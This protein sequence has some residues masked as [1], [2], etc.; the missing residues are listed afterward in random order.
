MVNTIG[1]NGYDNGDVPDSETLRDKLMAYV[2]EQLTLNQ[3]LRRLEVELGYSIGLTKLKQIQ[4]ELGIPTSRK[5]PSLPAATTLVCEKMVEDAHGGRGPNSI[6]TQLALEGNPLPRSIIRSVMHAH[7]PEGAALRYPGGRTKVKQRGFLRAFGPFHEW[8]ADG[9]EKLS[10]KA[11]RIG[12]VGMGIYGITDKWTRQII[13]TKCYPDVR[14]AAAVGHILADTISEV[15]AICIQLTVDHGSETADMGGLQI[16]LRYAIDPVQY[17]PFLTLKSTDNIS[18]E[19]KWKWWLEFGG[20]NLREEMLRGTEIGIFNGGNPLH[21][22]LFQWLW[23]QI[24]QLVLDDFKHAWNAKRI[25]KQKNVLLPTGGTPN[26]FMVRPQDYGGER[27]SI[28]VDIH[29][30]TEIR[31][32]FD[33]TREDAFRW[34]DDVFADAAFYAY[35]SIGSPELKVSTAWDTFLRML[36]VLSTTVTYD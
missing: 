27:V 30:V 15:G 14:H 10:S 25:R 11:L 5:P 18:I 22:D 4:R 19:S 2:G 12:P 31:S 28:P 24:V 8:H 29:N 16:T 32:N 21:C 9:H 33:T 7:H 3:R 20:R 13:H 6:K 1:V 17:P 26:D 34:V 36:P 35:Q 23:P